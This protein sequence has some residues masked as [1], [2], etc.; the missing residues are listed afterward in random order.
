MDVQTKTLGTVSITDKQK[1]FFPSGLFGFETYTEFALVEAEYHPFLWL[2][3]LQEKTLAFLV[4]DPFLICHDYELD[5]DDASLAPI[6]ITSPSDVCVLAV[7]TVPSGGAPVTVNLQGPLVICKNNNT[8]MQ[9]IV[10]DPRWTTK[11][12]ILEEVRKRGDA[13]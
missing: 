3:S 5:I 6:G 13:C 11:H 4:V 8:G 7:I 1:I 10:S 2:Q 9:V 12:N